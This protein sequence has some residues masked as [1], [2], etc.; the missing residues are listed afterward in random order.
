MPDETSFV[1]TSD[2]THTLTAELE[3]WR[4][5]MFRRL[6]PARD[7]FP[8]LHR[9]A[10]DTEPPTAWAARHY[11]PIRTFLVQALDQAEQV[12]GNA[13][14]LD[15]YSPQVLRCVFG[16][17]DATMNATVKQRQQA[18]SAQIP[19][20]FTHYEMTEPEVRGPQ[21][22]TLIAAI[23]GWRHARHAAASSQATEA[24]GPRPLFGRDADLTW[25]S[26]TRAQLK[27]TG[28]L[29]GIWGLQG[30]GKT[31]LA[32][33]FAWTI[34]PERT[35][36]IRVGQRGRY[37]EDLRST[38]TRAG[39]AVPDGSTEEYEAVFRRHVASLGDLWLLIVDGV[40]SPEDLDVLGV[41]HARIPVLV[42]AA[43]RFTAG[44]SHDQQDAMPWRQV[45]PLGLQAGLNLLTQRLAEPVAVDRSLLETLASLMGGHTATLEAVSRLLPE[46]TENDVQE[47]LKEVGRA[48]GVSL[49]SVSRF[50]GDRELRAVAQPLSWIIRSKLGQLA[51]DPLARSILIV[52]V[53]CSDSGTMPRLLVEAVVSEAL[54]RTPWRW[55]LNFAYDRLAQL[56]LATADQD[57]IST[58]RLVCHLARYE[59]VDH[60]TTAL[61]AYER[62]VAQPPDESAS[63]PC[64]LDVL[65]DEY[66]TASHLGQGHERLK[67]DPGNGRM[68]CVDDS[69]WAHYVTTADGD[70]HV[71][72]YRMIG[73]HQN[74]PPL[75]FTG[76]HDGWLPLE[77]DRLRRVGKMIGWYL[78]E[79]L[80][81]RRDIAGLEFHYGS[82]QSQ[83]PPRVLEAVGAFDVELSEKLRKVDPELT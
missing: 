54:G 28:G 48:P 74:V 56:G 59:V 19:D 75:R 80:I 3:T 18:A 4:K 55:D 47:L 14:P 67:E 44:L 26:Q 17:T 60:L 72:L 2:L 83:W 65:R 73:G 79:L 22:D 21:I 33:R 8:E 41:E 53:C 61:L 46:L 62:V 57:Q 30:I 24:G 58:E 51:D 13:G 36:T 7:Q 5:R 12:R 27:D 63:K 39:H 6:L 42:V 32:E 45:G 69:Y 49:A 16:L 64:L 20:L 29:F 71:E 82:D 37:A 52:L 40:S 81:A 25:L 78:E 77:G 23:Y 66:A 76:R 70:R 68:V 9:L 34:G 10:T 35:A 1:D 31:A 50:T 43:E 38:L 11:P 15:A